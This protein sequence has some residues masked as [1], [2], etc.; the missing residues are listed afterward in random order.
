M[1]D[2]EARGI[3]CWIAIINIPGGNRFTKEITRAIELCRVFVLVLSKEAQ[4]SGWVY[5]ELEYAIKNKKPIIPYFIEETE[6]TSEFHYLLSAH[7]GINAYDYP[8][9]PIEEL[10]C[11][12]THFINYEK[13]YREYKQVEIRCP[14]CKSARVGDCLSF[15]Q[16][17]WLRVKSFFEWLRVKSFFE[18]PFVIALMTG[19]IL[20]EAGVIIGPLLLVIWLLP[21]KWIPML[22]Q[23]LNLV[24][25]LVTVL[26]PVSDIGTKVIEYTL[27][28][29]LAIGI[30]CWIIFILF[31]LVEDSV[32]KRKKKQGVIVQT[33][34]CYNC[35]KRFR[36]K[37]PKPK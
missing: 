4:K 11:R 31:C 34:R 33:F 18:V 5:R 36:V 7:N 19:Y 37:I 9:N 14:L 23:K 29:A 32:K 17:L 35:N 2:L 27:C 13:N 12:I 8:G 22:L 1:R 21:T 24:N 15:K 26:A 10:A 6:L 25:D 3:S 30:L 16:S 20:V 28:G